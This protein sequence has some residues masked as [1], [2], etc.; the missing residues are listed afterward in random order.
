MFLKIILAVFSLVLPIIVNAKCLADIYSAGISADSISYD[1]KNVAEISSTIGTGLRLGNVIFCPEDNL[2]FIPTLRLRLV[3]F[4]DSQKS[5]T[6]SGIKETNYLFSVGTEIRKYI[7]N[8]YELVGDTELRQDVGFLY[9][10]N[11][12]IVSSK[13]YTNLKLMTGLRKYIVGKSRHDLSAKIK[14]GPLLPLAPEA[15]IGVIAG[16]SFEYMY[17]IEKRYSILFDA[18]LDHYHQEYLKTQIKRS[19]LGGMINTVFRF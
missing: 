7:K 6:L 18:Y 14:L 15:K 11:T 10:S 13:N 8:S 12:K 17:K 5:S 2:E 4:S 19:E 1:L 16:I 9:N 3:K